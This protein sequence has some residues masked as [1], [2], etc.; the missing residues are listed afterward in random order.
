MDATEGVTSL[1]LKDRR[2]GEMEFDGWA[3][4]VH[5]EEVKD[6]KGFEVLNLKLE[7]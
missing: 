7:A 5:G 6:K 1:V 4:R 2:K 3:V